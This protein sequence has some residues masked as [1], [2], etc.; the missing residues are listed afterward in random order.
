MGWLLI[1]VALGYL[2]WIYA[3]EDLSQWVNPLIVRASNLWNFLPSQEI[4]GNGRSIPEGKCSSHEN[5]GAAIDHVRIKHMQQSTVAGGHE[6][7]GAA[8]PF[9]VV[10]IGIDTSGARLVPFDTINGG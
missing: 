5:A 4:P 9:G 6:F 10:K 7:P 8:V 1:I 3:A 2:P